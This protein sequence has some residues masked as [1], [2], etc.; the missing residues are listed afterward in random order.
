MQSDRDVALL[1][2]FNRTYTRKL[3]LLDTYLDQSAFTLSETRIMFEIVTRQDPT[4]AEI[5]RTL[6][7]DRAQISRTLKRLGERGIIEAR[8]DP[9]HGRNQLLSLTPEGRKAYDALEATTRRGVSA[10]LDELPTTRRHQL[11]SAA[12][13][14]TTIFEAAVPLEVSLRALK[15]GDMG[16]IIH[17]QSVLYA[18]EHG[19]DERYEA[20]IA[21]ILVDYTDAFDSLRDAGWI[22]EIDGR[23]VGSIFL[24]HTD[25]KE[26]GKLRLLYVEPDARGSGVGKRLVATC[27]EHARRVGYSRLELWT[28]TVLAAARSIYERA[29]FEL[30][31]EAPDHF[32]GTESVSQT[33]SLTL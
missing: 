20:L 26:I 13:T 22:A 6:G 19:Y 4:A 7:L 27:V 29:G 2:T 16:L 9:S 18:E 14:I 25:R 23:I 12:Q 3:G 8:D 31:A 10:L 32:F 1:R 11:L 30:I 28:D 15:T 5:S 24:I 21:R 33:W 17:R